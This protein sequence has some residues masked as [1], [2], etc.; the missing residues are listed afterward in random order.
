MFLYIAMQ[1]NFASRG[2][3]DFPPV[4]RMTPNYFSL[5]AFSFA[6]CTIFTSEVPIA[7]AFLSFKFP[8]NWLQ[9]LTGSL[10]N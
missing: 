5:L 8:L 1:I 9:R 2:T 10:I 3:T 7:S 4:E 6:S